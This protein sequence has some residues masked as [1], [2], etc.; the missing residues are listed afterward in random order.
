MTMTLRE[1]PKQLNEA[2]EELLDMPVFMLGKEDHDIEVEML[3]LSD[4]GLVLMGGL[5]EEGRRTLAQQM[6]QTL[7]LEMD[8]T[9]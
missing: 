3:R 7:D 1:L 8:L 2:Y 6:A 9:K 5:S 4:E